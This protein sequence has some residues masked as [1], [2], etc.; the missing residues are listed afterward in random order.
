MQCANV[1]LS[2]HMH[3]RTENAVTDHWRPETIVTT[4]PKMVN[5]I[6]VR[7]ISND[8]HCMMG[9]ISTLQSESTGLY[10]PTETITTY[11][12]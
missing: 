5:I 6:A 3:K 9:L 11:I 7:K 1:V 4:T 10:R 2:S 12:R 8:V